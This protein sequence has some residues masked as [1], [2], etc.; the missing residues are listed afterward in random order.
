[1]KIETTYTVGKVK[2]ISCW[3][4]LEITCECGDKIVV[5]LS[6]SDKQSLADNLL[7]RIKN[8]K[9]RELESLTK[10]LEELE[11]KENES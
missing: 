10:D 3:S 7:S 5:P 2:Y 11:A 1:M 6:T 4:D 8:D 9:K